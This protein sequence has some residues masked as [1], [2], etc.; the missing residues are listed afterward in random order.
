MGLASFIPG[1]SLSL[2]IFGISVSPGQAPADYCGTF[3]YSSE[4]VAFHL[5]IEALRSKLRRIFDP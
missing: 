1:S 4:Y 2:A 3:L 5:N